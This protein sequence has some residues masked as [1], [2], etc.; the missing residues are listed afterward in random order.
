MKLHIDIV[1][2]IL[3]E[4]EDLSNPNKLPFSLDQDWHEGELVDVVNLI[5]F[6]FDRDNLVI[7]LVS[8]LSE[9]DIDAIDEIVKNNVLERFKHIDFGLRSEVYCRSWIAKMRAQKILRKKSIMVD[10]S[11]TDNFL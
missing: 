1:N 3:L 11:H 7:K 8:L 4:N 5:N 10:Q 2:N 9:A 6:L